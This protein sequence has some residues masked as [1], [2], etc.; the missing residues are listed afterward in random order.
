MSQ[1]SCSATMVPLTNPWSNRVSA[2]ASSSLPVGSSD[3]SARP[4]ISDRWERP[5]S[6]SPKP[7]GRRVSQRSVL[8]APSGQRRRASRGARW[9]GD[10][11]I[12]RTRRRSSCQLENWDG[13]TTTFRLL[14]ADVGITAAVERTGVVQRLAMG[15]FVWLAASQTSAKSTIQGGAIHYLRLRQPLA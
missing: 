3:Q 7:Y 4:S 11:R 1:L 15:P 14:L 5:A 2:R 9:T 8:S 6:D 12:P 10:Q 13:P